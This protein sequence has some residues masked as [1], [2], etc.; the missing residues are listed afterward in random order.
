[1]IG[2]VATCLLPVVLACGGDH[3]HTYAKRMQS[4]ATAS[5]SWPS[6]PLEWGD[7]NFLHT[8]DSH[9][10][11]LG[12]T[13]ASQ[14]EPNYSGDFGDF[15]SFVTNM[16]QIADKKGADLLLVDSGDLH[17]GT[18]LSDGFPVGQVDGQESNKFFFDVPYDVLAIGNHELYQYPIALDMHQ[19]FAPRWNGRYL[20]SNVNITY[21]DKNGRLVNTPVGDRFVKFRTKQYVSL[22]PHLTRY[23]NLAVHESKR[24]VTAFGVLFDFTGNAANTT[25]Q[26]VSVMVNE[27]WFKDAVKEE[28]DLFLLVGHMPVQKDNWPI[29]FNAIRAIHPTTPIFIF[30]GHTHIRDCVQLDSRSMSLESGRYME[31]IGWMSAKL[32]KTTNPSAPLSMTRRYLDPNRNT[33]TYH[34]QAK[35]FDTAKG[36]KITAGISALAKAWNL[37]QV[38]GTAPQDYYLSR[39]PYPSNSSV[40]TLLVNE[41]IPK[42]LAIGNPSRASIPSTVIVNSGSQRF[43]LYAGPFTRNDQFIVSPFNDAFLY[44]QVP[45]SIAKDVLDKLNEKGANK[46]RD[47]EDPHAYAR[48]EVD[49]RFNAWRRGQYERVYHERA[50]A[51]LTL[52]YVTTD[53]C[54]GVGD[55][56]L[57]SPIPYYDAPGYIASPLPPGLSGDTL[58]DIVFLDFFESDVLQIVNALSIGAGKIYSASDVQQY[59]SGDLLTNTIYGIFAAAE[60]N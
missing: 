21:T 32:P 59:G 22:L 5:S 45:A 35:R 6:A 26:K 13:K 49:H 27:T 9:G 52:G 10:W 23:N 54:P 39:M 31:T 56:T 29:V 36:K 3:D 46:K 47:T 28:P 44:F 48:G 58:V 57:H 19:N 1:M 37:T 38:Y 15:A 8:T 20:S 43:D 33:Y 4:D 7:I 53:S 41:V 12:H 55:D 60:W 2:L 42:A 51:N 18:G 16:K 25:V 17:D 40:L 11:L 14:P 50:T 30:G 34:T 24:K